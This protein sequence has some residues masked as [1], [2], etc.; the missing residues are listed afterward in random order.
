VRSDSTG[1][2]EAPYLKVAQRSGNL[3]DEVVVGAEST[4][5]AELPD[6]GGE[7]SELVA[8]NI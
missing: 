1:G 7:G 4:K 3:L 5:V 8:R 2:E 6:V